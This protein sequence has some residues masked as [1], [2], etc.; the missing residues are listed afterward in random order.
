MSSIF[1]STLPTVH[2]EGIV[3]RVLDRQSIRLTWDM[4][5]ATILS[6][7]TTNCQRPTNPVTDRP[8]RLRK[9]NNTFV[10]VEHGL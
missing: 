5:S 9:D 8:N 6:S 3:M 1:S 2:G 4:V 7:T 10:A